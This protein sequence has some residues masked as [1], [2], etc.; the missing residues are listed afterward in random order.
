MVMVTRR[1]D[2]LTERERSALI[3][4]LNQTD[5]RLVH[6]LRA[7]NAQIKELQHQSELIEDRRKHIA[8]SL[9]DLGAHR[10]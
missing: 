1:M 4:E 6:E 5:L 8:H 2:E 10:Q 9:G 7:L 3:L